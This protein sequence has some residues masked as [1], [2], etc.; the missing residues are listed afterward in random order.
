MKAGSV[1]GSHLVRVCAC[2]CLYVHVQVAAAVVVVFIIILLLFLLLTGL[3]CR[4]E[5][6]AFPVRLTPVPAPLFGGAL[7]GIALR[8][9]YQAP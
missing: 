7:P 6:R 3:V 8:K 5:C 2:I 9:I 4:L 1:H